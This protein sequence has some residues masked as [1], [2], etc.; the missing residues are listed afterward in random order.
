[1]LQAVVGEHD[2]HVRACQ[3]RPHCAAAVWIHHHRA[4]RAPGDHRRFVAAL[5]RWRALRNLQGVRGFAAVAA[6]DDPR[7]LAA[8]GKPPRQPD[9]QRRLASAAGGDV[10]HHHHRRGRPPR[11]GAAAQI[12]LPPPRGE[13]AEHRAER[14]Q[15]ARPEAAVV[16]APHQWR[17]GCGH[18][19]R[20]RTARSSRCR[21]GLVH[22]R[23]ELRLVQ[24]RV[25]A[26]GGHEGG[27]V[28]GFH[29]RAVLHHGDQ[30]RLLHG[31]Q[32]VGDDDGGATTHHL[33]Q[34]GLHLLLGGGVQGRGGLVENQHG[35][36]L[37]Q[38]AGNGHALPLAAGQPHAVVADNGVDSVRQLVD[39]AL[40]LGAAHGGVNGLLVR[41]GQAAIGDVVRQRVVEQRDVLGDQRDLPPQAGEAIAGQ[42]LAVEQDAPAGR[43]VE[44]RDEAGQGGLAGPGTTNQGDGLSRPHGE[45][46]IAQHVRP[47]RAVAKRDL[48]ETDFT[49]HSGHVQMAAVLL[50]ALVELGED[51]V[52]GRKAPLQPGIQIRE[53]LDRIGKRSGERQITG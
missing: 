40:G 42:G 35:R 13:P 45:G 32:A 10:A 29:H 31:G 20:R 23:V 21:R 9:H 4:A 6:R 19:Q 2:V 7:L 5:R 44:A 27:V 25:G 50:R 39:E 41:A 47:I 30:V 14:P 38:G 18:W 33:L 48:L 49:T 46:D 28:A 11:L 51:V 17:Q 24:F 53:L 22:R 37:Q 1:M 15:Q 16:P 36:V 8:R 52:R 3:Q 34:G 12:A 43:F 26:A